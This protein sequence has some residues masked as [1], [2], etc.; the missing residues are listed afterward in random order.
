MTQHTSSALTPGFTPDP[1]PDSTESS[2]AA[3]ERANPPIGSEAGIATIREQV[4][5]CLWFSDGLTPDEVASR[6]GL[7]VLTVRPRCSEL[8]RHGRIVDSGT[9]RVNASGRKA[10]VLVVPRAGFFRRRG[11]KAS[12]GATRC[13]AG[14]P[15]PR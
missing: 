10:K 14:G 5:D 13:R 11:A 6:L 12:A 4:F 7:S 9:R 2:E 3:T 1:I 15:A 8:M